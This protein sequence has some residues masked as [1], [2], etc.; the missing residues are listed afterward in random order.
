MKKMVKFFVILVLS[1]MIVVSPFNGALV[2]AE[3]ASDNAA[4]SEYKSK[5]ISG[6]ADIVF[7]IDSTG[8]MEPY[9][10]SVKENLVSFVSYLDEKKVS[11][12]MSVVEYRDIEED[13]ID[14]TIVHDIGG[15]KW[16][17]DV[18]E[19]IDVFESI[20]VDGGGDLPETPIAAFEQLSA[21]PREDSDKFIFLLTDAN[22]KDYDDTEDNHNKNHY[23]MKSWTESFRNSNVKVTVVSETKYEDEYNYL[24]T[25]TGGRFIDINSKNYYELMQEYSEWIY[26]NAIDSDGDGL[27]DDWEI[28][29]VDANH[30]GVIDIDLAAMGAD[31]NVP[32]IFIE[33]D[34]M[35][36]EGDDFNFL[37]IQEKVNQKSTA[38]SATALE[39]IYDQFQSHGINIHIDA[40]PNSVMNY[41]TGEKW[42]SLSGA[43]ALTYQEI[44][45]VGSS[46]ENW[47]KMA[48][49][50][51]TR[52]RWT[53][54]R[55]CLF[56]N[57]YDAG[58][59]NRRSGIAESIP[60]QF[61][62]VASGCIGGDYDTALAGTF[63]HELGHTL[64][65]SHGGLYTDVSTGKL[66]NNH[67]NYKPNHL[68]IMNYTYQ[69]SGM[70]TVLGDYIVN[71]QDFKLPQID[72]KHID[73]HNGIDP[74]GATEGTGLTIRVPVKNKFLF[75]EWDG[76]KDAGVA[77]Q[78]IDFNRN[79]TIENDILYDLNFDG[80]H[81]N[82]TG[83]LNEWD[84]LKFTGCLIGGYGEEVNVDEV[85]TLVAKTEM[86]DELDELS[87][88]EAFEKGLLGDPGE[89]QFSNIFTKKLFTD[90]KN[91][92]FEC[93]IS[94]LYPEATNVELKV[95]SD[96][97]ATEYVDSIT[98]S[99]TGAVVEIPVKDNLTKGSYSITYSMQL[100]NGETITETG[101]A[102]VVPTDTITMNVGDTEQIPAD[103]VISCTSSNDSVVDIDN[104]KIIAK[105]KGIAYVTV[106]FED[107]IYC[108]KVTVLNDDNINM[109]I[110]G[111]V[112]LFVLLFIGIGIVAIVVSAKKHP[113]DDVENAALD[114]PHRDR[115]NMVRC[116]KCGTVHPSDKPCACW[117]EKEEDQITE[118]TEQ[119]TGSI[120]VISGSM[121]GFA[122]PIRDGETLCLGKDPKF[123][124]IVFTGNYE[125][126]SRMHCTIT[127]DA[128]KKHY[129]VVDCSSNGT[130]LA[131]KVRME[132][133]K[134]TV[135]MPK[136]VITLAN[137]NCTILLG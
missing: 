133:G 111:I 119:R 14:S 42:G 24:Y 75:W 97:L 66:T 41:E 4:I 105:R 96:I 117:G 3:D 21:F 81:E 27:P 26:E 59:G 112:A 2:E 83:T 64:G 125:K 93:K 88:D 107:D 131:G 70:K 128:A 15:M 37:G 1:L 44:F 98:V 103:S 50:N 106:V 95:S 60:G 127:Y 90:Q 62:I 71:Y 39:M 46:L 109:V 61:F 65:L 73:E 100:K 47:N 67:D 56:V 6:S 116:A 94:N 115:M 58:N 12:N 35:E 89:C 99:E 102:D 33:A 121:N 104:E 23:S 126:V 38:P 108:T 79:G 76:E 19:V 45:Y 7:V 16:T 113:V 124:N 55:Y 132:K 48:I 13:G 9:I 40:G 135:V 5:D 78:P 85:T 54:F 87:F 82:L 31:P 80:K 28:D 8:S 74:K 77:K 53:T 129:Y 69:F 68:S 36:Y 18:K 63:M 32:D 29:G 86:N 20:S 72:E 130:F 43:G 25:M 57:Q 52:A 120:Q 101:T 22:Y 51:F 122:A 110:F 30:D 114:V 84:N 49:D 10:T 137:G 118:E 34:W 17:S 123:A 136:T 11:L 92:S 91:Q 134:R